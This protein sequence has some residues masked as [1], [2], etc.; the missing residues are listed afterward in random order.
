VTPA[1]C[2]TV[3]DLCALLKLPPRTF[4]KLR[5]AGQLPFVEELRPRLGRRPRYRADL[6]DR[7]LAGEWGQSR[8]LSSHRRKVAV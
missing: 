6:I 1:R 4:R 5:A 3:E 2:Y 8:Y 7:Y